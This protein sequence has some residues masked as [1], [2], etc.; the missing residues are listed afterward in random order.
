M[1]KIALVTGGTRGIGGAVSKTL[2][3][4]NYTVIAN[5]CNNFQGAEEFSKEHN[6]KVM[7]WNVIN[8]DEC[9]KAIKDI[10]EQYQ[11]PV[12]ILVNNAGI[13][14]D[15]MMHKMTS[16]D[17]QDVISTNLN[18]CFNM[19]GAVINQMRQQNFGRIINISS[20]NGQIGQAGQTNYSAAKAG[21][22]GFTKALA[23]ESAAKGITV[24]CIAPGYIMTEMVEKVPSY[25]LEQIISSIPMKRLGKPSEIARAVVFLS[26]EEASFITGETISINGGYSMY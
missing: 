19:C 23:K 6:I 17:W 18:S 8:R 24:N 10:E 11:R 1:S 12:S 25:T 5:F 4:N 13:T 16:D 3:E 22:I 15:C 7:N 26:D 21:M 2:A 9:S 20:V 14:K